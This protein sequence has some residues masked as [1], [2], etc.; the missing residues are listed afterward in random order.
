MP[1]LR[2]HVSI[3]AK[4]WVIVCEQSLTFMLF[5]K[6]FMQPVPE[7]YRASYQG[8]GG[9]M[10]NET[11]SDLGDSSRNEVNKF[12]GPIRRP[13]RSFKPREFERKIYLYIFIFL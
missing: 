2:E 9:G 1:R 13:D 5:L 10:F 4:Q 7:V 11:K 8:Y 3:V 12:V 6:R